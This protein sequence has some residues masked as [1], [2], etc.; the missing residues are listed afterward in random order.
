VG[1]AVVVR[2]EPRVNADLDVVERGES[3]AEVEHLSAHGEPKALH[4]SARFGI[5]RTRV[6]EGDSESAA[7][8]AENVSAV[9]RAVVEVE[10]IGLSVSAERSDEEVEHVLL[11]LRGDD[12]KRDDEAGMVVHKCVHAD[13]RATVADEESRTVADVAVPERI[14]AKGLPT[15]ARLR[16]VFL[17]LRGKARESFLPKE[18]TDGGGADHLGIESPVGGESRADERDGG[19]RKLAS[20]VEEELAKLGA[21]VTTSSAIGPWRR[22]EGARPGVC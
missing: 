8:E 18:P 14:G 5:V 4:L 20:D 3:I 22:P 9:G 17:L 11:A 13:G 7:E 1:S 19:C 10:G 2:I 12:A 6:Q 16:A 15:Q 21:E